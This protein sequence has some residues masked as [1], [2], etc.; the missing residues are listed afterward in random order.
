MDGLKT[1]FEKLS[2]VDR[3]DF[4]HMI[5]EMSVQV[6]QGTKDELMN[7]LKKVTA[8][9]NKIN[10]S[11]EELT[12]R[13]DRFSRFAESL[14][15]FVEGNDNVALEICMMKKALSAEEEMLRKEIADM[16]PDDLLKHKYEI[17]AK[18]REINDKVMMFS[19]IN[20]VMHKILR[21]K[22]GFN[23]KRKSTIT[24]K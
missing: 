13:A 22:E 7:E 15:E 2:S 1:Y 6:S 12:S 14:G 9:I 10:S 11:R 19:K 20:N 3:D 24:V 16:R 4:L 21:R 18:L 5:S 17:K 23:G 8:A